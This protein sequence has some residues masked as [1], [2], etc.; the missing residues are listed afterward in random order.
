MSF[1]INSSENP[2]IPI[3]PMVMPAIKPIMPQ[4]NKL[5]KSCKDDA[6]SLLPITLERTGIR[7][8]SKIENSIDKPKKALLGFITNFLAFAGRIDRN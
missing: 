5:G 2:M 7:S 8:A 6:L 3:I 4:A 1:S